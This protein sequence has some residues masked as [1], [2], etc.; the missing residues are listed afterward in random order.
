MV[1]RP[2]PI[3]PYG[4]TTEGEGKECFKLIRPKS[5]LGFLPILHPFG[6]CPRSMFESETFA[7]RFQI[8]RTLMRIKEVK[9]TAH[10]ISNLLK[11]CEEISITGL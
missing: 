3:V 7:F 8:N 11:S 1:N 10:D 4:F 2:I 6:N 9:G 5:E